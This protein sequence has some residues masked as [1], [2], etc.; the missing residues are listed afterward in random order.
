[1][2][3]VEVSVTLSTNNDWTNAGFKLLLDDGDTKDEHKMT[4]EE[5]LAKAKTL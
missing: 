2:S 1:L 5:R 4:K 3:N